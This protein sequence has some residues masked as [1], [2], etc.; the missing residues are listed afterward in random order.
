M[1]LFSFLSYLD[2]LP[3]VI[4]LS[5]NALSNVVKKKKKQAA[6][7]VKCDLLTQ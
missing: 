7:L 6:L 2:H 4:M 5:K 1:Y 3:A